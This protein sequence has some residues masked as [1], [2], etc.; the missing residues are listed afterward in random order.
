MVYHFKVHKEK[1][2]FW[3]QGI[4]LPG[5]FAQGA[6]AKE[7]QGNMQE[8]L[9]LYLEE[10]SDSG[11][12]VPLP[13]DT[14]KTTKTVVA[15]AVDPQTAFAFLVRYFRLKY[16][17]TQQQAAKKMGFDT[18]Y[19]YQRLEARRCNPSL[20]MMLK[21]KDVFPEFSLDAVTH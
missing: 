5:C 21:V 11:D 7:L 15:V 20:K 14:I 9:Q 17:L 10:P 3:A 2:E 6:T 1:G 18:L 8:A 12:L 13:D 16:G 19:S 4:E